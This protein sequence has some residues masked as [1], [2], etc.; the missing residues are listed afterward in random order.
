MSNKKF[1][2]ALNRESQKTPPIW[3]MRQAGRYHSHYQKLK[4]KYDFMQLCKEPELAAQ[5]ALGPMQDFD[6]DVSILFSDLL[7]PLEALGMGLKYAP[8]PVLDRKLEPNMLKA[9][10][11]LNEAISF[12]QFQSDAVKITR[13]LLP[14][15][16]SLIGFV[17]GPWTLFNYA[18][19]GEHDG[20]L[21]EAK[22]LTDFYHQ[23]SEVIV[24]FLRKNIELQLT[25]GA[26][27]V[28]IFDTAAGNVS[29]L[30]FQE[31]LA[32][33]LSDLA[34]SFPGKTAYYSKGT[35]NSHLNKTVFLD[36]NWAG[37]G[38]DHRWDLPELL[39]TRKNGFVQGNFDQAF[40]FADET[41]FLKHLNSYLKPFKELSEDERKGWVCGLGHGVLPK[42]PEANV[43][44][45]IEV[46]RKE[47]S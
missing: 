1:Q 18:V 29:S 31:H 16:K 28:M 42:T 11:P 10:K 24:P 19:S 38:V 4:E 13:E 7:F 21:I 41:Q 30:Y 2:N 3:F 40:L 36:S 17:G 25:A 9:L 32:K 44:K 45:F 6:F 43:R 23:F 26:E 14:K 34:K 8:G 47:F 39:K 20:N 15:D 33:D 5:V 22:R 27:L 12:M 35:L 46:I 37:I